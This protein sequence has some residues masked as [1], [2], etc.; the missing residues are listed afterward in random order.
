M[1]AYRL[2]KSVKR[3]FQ[4]SRWKKKSIISILT[5]FFLFAVSFLWWGNIGFYYAVTHSRTVDEIILSFFCILLQYFYFLTV[6]YFLNLTG[7]TTVLHVPTSLFVVVD[8]VQ[9]CCT[10]PVEF[11]QNVFGPEVLGS[12]GT[13]PTECIF[14]AKEIEI[15]AWRLFAFVALEAPI[16]SWL[17]VTETMASKQEITL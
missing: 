3:P 1:C 16:C 11:I 13:S 14:G 8:L 2:F 4:S 6:S 7:S 12:L 9:F 15:F 5:L 17:N 10:H